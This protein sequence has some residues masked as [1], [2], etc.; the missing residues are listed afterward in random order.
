M[1]FEGNETPRKEP[2]EQA[3]TSA[4]EPDIVGNPSTG[5]EPGAGKPSVI[6]QIFFG[7]S[8]RERGGGS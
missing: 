8:D 7:P 6:R 1:T 4:N 5:G 3:T 2:A